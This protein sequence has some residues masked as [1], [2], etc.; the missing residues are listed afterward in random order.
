M[1]KTKN[2]DGLSRTFQAI[3]DKVWTKWEKATPRS[4]DHS[5]ADL[6]CTGEE[7]G[8]PDQ[9]KTKS[10]RG[11]GIVTSNGLNNLLK[12]LLAAK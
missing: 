2:S 3:N 8:L 11:T 9:F 4:L 12:I 10:F 6:G 5:H 1:P 7:F